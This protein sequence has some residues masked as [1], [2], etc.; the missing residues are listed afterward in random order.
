[1]RWDVRGLLYSSFANWII[2]SPSWKDKRNPCNLPSARRGFGGESW[3]LILKDLKKLIARKGKGYIN[4]SSSSREGYEWNKGEWGQAM[5]LHSVYFVCTRDHG[6]L[7]IK[8]L[9]PAG[10]LPD[11]TGKW[12]PSLNLTPCHCQSH[13]CRHLLQH[14]Q[15]HSS[16]PLISYWELFSQTI[17]GQII[18]NSGQPFLL[19]KTKTM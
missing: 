6:V 8:D 1:M 17:S 13:R 14:C 19:S 10:R 12:Y 4:T 3:I 16:F 7:E 9:R 15:S 2:N 5:G 18:Q 11:M